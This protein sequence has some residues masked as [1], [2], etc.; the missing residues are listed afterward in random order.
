MASLK[1][2]VEKYGIPVKVKS[3]TKGVRPFTIISD[4]GY[5][6]TV[7]YND[8]YLGIQKGILKEYPTCNDYEYDGKV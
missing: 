5:T 2:I 1:S 8:E 6:Y 7:D 3:T 4:D